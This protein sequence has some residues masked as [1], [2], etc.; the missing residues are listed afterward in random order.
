MQLFR[1]RGL[2]M[3]NP[4]QLV[5][6]DYLRSIIK[7]QDLPQLEVLKVMRFPALSVG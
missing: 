4:Y 6:R 1:S 3:P 2:A 5:V 7:F